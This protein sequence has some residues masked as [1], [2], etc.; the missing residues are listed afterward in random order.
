VRAA[1]IP[2][3]GGVFEFPLP[4]FAPASFVLSPAP[5]GIRPQ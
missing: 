1:Q 3:Q 4:A 2:V 5:A